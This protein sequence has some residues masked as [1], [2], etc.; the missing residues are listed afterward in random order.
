MTTQLNNVYLRSGGKLSLALGTDPTRVYGST[1]ADVVTIAAGV[2]VVLDGS[3][4]RGNDIIRFT[5]N[6]ASYSVV[7]VNASTVRIT[8]AAGTSVTIPVGSAGTAIEFADATRTLSGSSAGILLGNQTI[9]ATPVALAAGTAPAPVEEYVLTSSAPTVTEGNDGTKTLTYLL[10]L[11]KAPTSEVTVNYQTTDAGTAAAGDD[12]QVVAGIA[13]FAPG[14]TA[15]TVSVTVYADTIVEADE[16]VAL[17]LSGSKLVAAV[18]ALGTIRNDD[19]A[20]VDPSAYTVTAGDIA[21]ANASNVPVTLNI[22][23]TGN[24][25]VTI[26]SDGASATQGIIING[27]ANATVNSGA[28]G[29]KITISGNGI[30]TINTGGG[31][32]NVSVYGSGT[33]TINVGTGNDTVVGGTGD[34]TVIFAAGALGAGD[35]VDGGAGNDTVR[36]SGDGNVIG[37]FDTNNNGVVDAGD[38]NGANLI[39]VENI[40]FDGTTVSI[41][42]ATLQTLI[43]NGLKSITGSTLTTELTIVG[44]QAAPNGTLNLSGIAINGG[45]EKITT[46]GNGTLIL[47]TTQ[48]NQIAAISASTGTLTQQVIVSGPQ[49]VAMAEALLA[50]GSTAKFTLVDTAANLALAPKAVFAN[51]VSVEATTDATA[52]QAVQIASVI[53]SLASTNASLYTGSVFVDAGIKVNVTDTASMLAN[54]VSGLAIADKVTATTAATTAEAKA[55]WAANTGGTLFTASYAVVDSA[56][57]LT[58][59]LVTLDTANNS[60]TVTTTSTAGFAIGQ[61]VIG[62]GIPEGATITAITGGTTF[63]ISAAATATASNV[64][65]RIDGLVETANVA[66]LNN[67]NSV[68]FT[69][70]ATPSI[71]Q[72]AAL[73]AALADATGGLTKVSAGYKLND[74]LANLTNPTNAAI[75]SAAGDVSVVTAPGNNTLAA[76]GVAQAVAVEALSNSGANAYKL[77]DTPTLLRSAGSDVT[78]VAIANGG[79]TATGANTDALTVSELNA[80]VAKFGGTAFSTD[81][82][83]VDTAA[84]IV[85]LTPA[86][87]AEARPLEVS[88]TSTATVAE[89]L[90]LNKFLTDNTVSITNNVKV[91]DTAASLEAAVKVP[92]TLAALDASQSVA[93]DGNATVK[94]IADINTALSSVNGAG[95][96]LTSVAAGYTLEDSAAKLAAEGAA[97]IIDAAAKVTVT[98]TATVAE[99]DI[100]ADAFAVSGALGAALGTTIKYALKDTAA[101]LLTTVLTVDGGANNTSVRADYVAAASSV[102]LS[103]TTITAAQAVSLRDVPAFDRVYAIEDTVAGLNAANLTGG[104]PNVDGRAALAG[105]TKVTL[106][107]SLASLFA[108]GVPVAAQDLASTVIASGT[109]AQLTGGNAVDK[110]KVDGF[111]ITNGSTSAVVGVQITDVAAVNALSAIAPTQ[112][113]ILGTDYDILMGNGAGVATF[114]ANAAEVAVNDPLTVAEFNT[115]DARAGGKLTYTLTDSAAAL[116]ASGAAAATAGTQQISVD[117][118]GNKAN[119]TVAEAKVLIARGITGFTIFDTAENITAAGDLLLDNKV[120]AIVISDGGEV[121]LSVAAADKVF[122]LNVNGSEDGSAAAKYNLVDTASKLAE[123][124]ADLIGFAQNVTATTVATAIDGATLAGRTSMGQIVF[125]VSDA[126]YS[127]DLNIAA[128]KARNVTVTGAISVADAVHLQ[129]EANTGTTS[130]KISDSASDLALVNNAS[131][132]AKIAAIEAATGTVVVNNGSD[133][134]VSAEQATLIAAY[135]KPVVYDI[136]S[137][138]ADLTAATVSAGATSEA[139]NIAITDGT[140]TAARAAQVLALSNSG[141]VTFAT[142]TGAAADILG[143]AL[144]KSDTATALTVS[145]ETSVADAASLI[146]KAAGVGVSGISLTIDTIKDTAAALAA[147]KSATVAAGTAVVATTAATVDEAAK[148]YAA[149]NT[150]VF[151]ITD[152][153]ANI[154][155]NSDAVTDA[156][157]GSADVDAV[158]ALSQAVKVTISDA[159]TVAQLLKVANEAGGSD[160]A[161][162]EIADVYRIVDADANIATAMGANAALLVKAASVTLV[163]GTAVKFDD[164]GGT[165]HIV[166]SLAEIQALPASLASANKLIEASVAELTANQAFFSSLPGNVNYRVVDTYANLTSGNALINV[167]D[168]IT[169]TDNITM[170]QA[171]TVR[172]L[173]VAAG[174]VNYSVRDTAEKLMAGA[175]SIDDTGAVQTGTPG[176]VLAAAINVEATTPVTVGEAAVLRAA[177]GENGK[178][179][180][181]ITVTDLASTLVAENAAIFSGATNITVTATTGGSI[182]ATEAAVILSAKNSGNTVIS[183]VYAAVGN[184]ADLKALVALKGANETISKVTV[185]GAALVADIQAVQAL[186]STLVYSLSDKAANLVAAAGATLNG[187]TSITLSSGAATLEQLAVIDAATP[188]NA[189]TTIAVEDTAANILAASPALLARANGAITIK[190]TSLTASQATQ[191]AALDAANDTFAI[192]VAGKKIVDTSANLLLADNAAAVGAAASVEVSDTVSTQRAAQIV[193]AATGSPV[194]FNISDV[195]ANLALDPT[196]AGL[197]NNVTITNLLSASQARTASG[198]S[199]DGTL[200]FSVRDTAAQLANPLYTLALAKAG[201]ITVSTA[202]TVD[203][204]GKLS[205]MAN[206]AS[207]SIKDSA[208]DVFN[209]LNRVNAAGIADRDT[210]LGAT[211]ITLEDGA[212]VSEVVGTSAAAT[213]EKLG[214]GSIP[215]LTFKVSDTGAAIA[216]ALKVPAQAS[217]LLNATTVELSDT[218]GVSVANLTLMKDVLGDAFLYHDHDNN[219]LTAARY[220]IKDTFTNILAADQPFVE[221]AT[222]LTVDGTEGADTIDM[223]GLSKN[224]V[225]YGGSGADAITGGAG[226]DLIDGGLGADVLTGGSGSDVFFFAAGSSA[227]TF[228]G[229]GNSGTVNGYDQITDFTLAGVDTLEVSG[230]G[231]VAANDTLTNNSTLTIEGA[232]ISSIKITNGAVAFSAADDGTSPITITSAA[233]LAAA[234]QALTVNDIGSAGDTTYFT[235]TIGNVSHTYVYTQTGDSAGGDLVD[236]VGLSATSLIT[237]GTTSGGILIG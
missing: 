107:D 4:N 139:R 221:A 121:T 13:T 73:N 66:A 184:I 183:H 131:N 186:S 116:A 209:A 52:A 166:G 8:D 50:S 12:F 140:L 19:S 2:S 159:V 74:T 45:L 30:N 20:P 203:E 11:N 94:Q 26:Q 227:P 23:N 80:L 24:K 86:A 182:N 110:S 55:I 41:S 189:N 101:A 235:A 81:R 59:R 176:A 219:A 1:D 71:V 190:D 214:L 123:A 72:V 208:T 21:A 78:A 118:S 85:K 215:G 6:A 171:A 67:A 53:A 224:M 156:N 100:I 205:E 38:F 162:Y 218:T 207:Y 132:A 77:S 197:A 84:E 231:R 141:K 198:W 49:S 34:E 134:N 154:M 137:S 111:R 196:T 88:S 120:A 57:A 237:T 204:A 135:A 76:I 170:A 62:A 163:N 144:N 25:T 39:G 15:T 165:L 5:G 172:G 97:T 174:E 114:V 98:G 89:L 113:K 36:V 7:R 10:T 143:L 157:S 173:G 195:Y 192:N 65:G 47:N 28:A 177:A 48:A 161:L 160:Q 16:T 92:T 168:G 37:Y 191:L 138:Y 104:N 212:R 29:D 32:D 103:N 151:D 54:N 229:A 211:S 188:S 43:Q 83:V 128:G 181:S 228:A 70:T 148:I 127:D 112:Y 14:Q 180:Y 99:I 133:A 164:I 129:A 102:S 232:V 147:A 42:A 193:T 234:I 46:N 210:V 51:A 69:A 222:T 169:V 125:D 130:Y 56:S 117:V 185:D 142:V 95:R 82:K 124:D 223:S 200:T 226:A 75:V 216:A 106:V 93:V 27:D 122:D 136:S 87:L 187:A 90:S 199:I 217:V 213:G 61:V 33:N 96:A 206:V 150:A 152:S 109:L 44:L 149:K 18:D 105:A 233:G 17:R 153:Y 64:A 79:A 146:A 22:G 31:N 201:A 179:T 119:A 158:L 155:R 60:P 145:G 194:K 175:T 236:L 58:S 68:S 225:I 3:F 230:L 115:L 178:A 9:T 35:V 220:Y 63:T 202:A 91:K 167:A 108:N 40:I 126:T